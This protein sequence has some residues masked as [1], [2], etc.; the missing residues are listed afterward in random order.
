MNSQAV[1]KIGCCERKEKLNMMDIE[2]SIMAT[3]QGFDELLQEHKKEIVES[4]ELE[5]VGNEIY[6]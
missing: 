2:N 1:D 3:K 5:I 4:Y 6:I